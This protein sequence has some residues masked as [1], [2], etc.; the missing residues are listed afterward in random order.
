[1]A[2][3]GLLLL[4][5]YACAGL[6]Q[7]DGPMVAVAMGAW[8]LLYAAI[9]PGALDAFPVIAAFAA[10]SAAI[11][12]PVVAMVFL[13]FLL[14][15][16]AIRG[17]Y[18][19][20]GACVGYAGYVLFV[21]LID[22]G[23]V[24]VAAMALLFALNVFFWDCRRGIGR[25]DG[26]RAA[27]YAACV[28][29]TGYAALAMGH[30]LSESSSRMALSLELSAGTAVGLI[31]LVALCSTFYSERRARA[32]LE[33]RAFDD[34]VPRIVQMGLAVVAAVAVCGF[35]LGD[36]GMVGTQAR[37]SFVATCAAFLVAASFA[38]RSEPVL[39]AVSVAACVAGLVFLIGFSYDGDPAWHFAAVVLVLAAHSNNLRWLAESRV[40]PYWI[41]T[42]S[43][44]LLWCVVQ[45]YDGP[46]WLSTASFFVLAGAML[47][48]GY[49]MGRRGV[50]LAGMLVICFGICK[51]LLLDLDYG[52]DLART[53]SFFFAGVLCLGVSMAY[54]R[55]GVG[56]Q[57]GSGMGEAPAPEGD[58][59]GSE[60]ME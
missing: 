33:A 52:S 17:Q 20:Q 38:R 8:C 50:R 7:A 11:D 28:A 39:R 16:A 13:A 31:A 37:V 25:V 2:F 48:A 1:M 5:G 6:V 9:Q 29:A 27:G 15:I 40:G 4:M 3:Q 23:S 24:P 14:N 36:G 49:K 46:S 34:F 19:L 54:H 57:D 35:L 51:L 12:A 58:T 47:Y 55:L 60:D 22:M 32:L 18:L 21:T 59:A 45:S 42:K 10:V 56:R 30:A 43:M 44:G 41:A 26:L 53:A